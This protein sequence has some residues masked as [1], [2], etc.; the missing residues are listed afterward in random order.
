[1]NQLKKK[2]VL[3]ILFKQTLKFNYDEKTIIYIKSI[4]SFQN[5]INN[6]YSIKTFL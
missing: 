2:K 3:F 4:I 6:K 1:M 5:N